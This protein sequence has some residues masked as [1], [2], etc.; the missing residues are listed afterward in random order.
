LLRKEKRI[1]NLDAEIPHG[2][3]QLCMAQ[4][5]LTGAQIAS[6]FIDQRDLRAAETWPAAGFVDT[7]IRCFMKPEVAYA[8]KTIWA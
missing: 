2:A 6:P 5:E 3:F 8:A 1:V 7:E 4:E